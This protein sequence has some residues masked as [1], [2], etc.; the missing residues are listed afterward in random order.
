MNKK[1]KAFI[2][3]VSVVIDKYFHDILYIIEYASGKNRYVFKN[4][5]TAN[6]SER[7]HNFIYTGMLV[8]GTNNATGTE[9]KYKYGKQSM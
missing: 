2:I 4:E 5:L 6:F 1:E 8:S 7:I 9:R 3:S